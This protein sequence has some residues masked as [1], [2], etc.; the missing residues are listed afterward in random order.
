[1]QNQVNSCS[2]TIK[3][4]DDEYPFIE[5]EPL[6]FYGTRQSDSMVEY[7][8]EPT[9]IITRIVNRNI[10]CSCNYFEIA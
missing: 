6:N 4:V 1:M 9:I 5:G 3:F 8:S 7:C 10:D 2:K